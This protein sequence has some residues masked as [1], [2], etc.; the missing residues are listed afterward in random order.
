MDFS[1]YAVECF[2]IIEKGFLILPVPEF[3]YIL[4]TSVSVLANVPEMT[5]PLMK[6]YELVSEQTLL[7]LSK[8]DIEDRDEL[9]ED[10]FGLMFRYTKYLPSVILS[11]KTLEESLQLAQTMI[12]TDQLS[13]QKTLCLFLEYLFQLPRENP[14]NDV[15][16]VSL[17]FKI[18]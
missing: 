11:S 16:K 4:E 17:A 5:E 6:T 18:F 7:I 12:A 10:F 2:E 13:V 9:C 3:L 1:P 15:E 14:Q 8:E